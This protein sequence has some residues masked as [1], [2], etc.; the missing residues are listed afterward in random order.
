MTRQ[1][2]VEM[3]LDVVSTDPVQ[4]KPYSPV[5][6]PAGVVVVQVPVDTVGIVEE[7]VEDGIVVTILDMHGFQSLLVSLA[8]GV[9]AVQ[10]QRTAARRK[11]YEGED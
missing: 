11:V 8:D 5:F 2:L 10:D 7:T 6:K 3:R 1:K 4:Y 9:Q